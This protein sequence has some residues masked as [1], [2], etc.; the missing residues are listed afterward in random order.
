MSKVAKENLENIALLEGLTTDDYRALEKR[1]TWH[2]CDANGQIL[3][4]DSD[5]RDVFF[6]VHGTVRVVNF[7]VSGREVSYATIREG[8]Y[9]GELSAVDGEPRSASVVAHEDCVLASLSPEGFAELISSNP[10]VAMRTM[11]KLALIIRITNDRIMDLTTL[12]AHQRVFLELLRLSSE[13]PVNPGGW[14]IYPLPTQSQI[15][16]RAGTTRETVARVLGRLVKEDI[17]SRKGKSL[18]VRN[19]DELRHLAEGV[20]PV[21]E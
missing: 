9:F 2:H 21:T 19:M 11:R 3:A 10:Q 1:C 20:N 14:V 12:G 6:V 15:A 7:S 16:S 17:V 4:R 5:S 8:D 18:Y 13:D